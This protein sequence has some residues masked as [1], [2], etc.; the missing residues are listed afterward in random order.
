MKTTGNIIS[1]TGGGFG[2]G[3]GLAEAFHSVALPG[4]WYFVWG[5]IR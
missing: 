4:A 3:R 1:I 5:A 2:I